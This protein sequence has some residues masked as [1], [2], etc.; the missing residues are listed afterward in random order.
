MGNSCSAHPCPQV[1][2]LLGSLISH[3][4]VPH[5]HSF[6]TLTLS[7]LSLPPAIHFTPSLLSYLT[8]FCF[9]FSFSHCHLLLQSSPFHS[10]CIHL[11]LARHCPIPSLFSSFLS[12][13]MSE[14]RSQ[15]KTSPVHSCHLHCLTWV[16]PTHF[17]SIIV[18][19]TV[20]FNWKHSLKGGKQTGLV[21][22]TC[23]SVQNS[24]LGWY[25]CCETVPTLRW[26]ITP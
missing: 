9:L 4:R 11:S 13:S 2:L 3:S 21:N 14:E 23:N 26:D 16:T 24:P 8:C 25:I 5:F 1:T 6:S 7:S 20:H 22:F 10:P 18:S 17:L 12:H 19:V 15:S